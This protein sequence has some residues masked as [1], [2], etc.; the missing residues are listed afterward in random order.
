MQMKMDSERE[1]EG[2]VGEVVEEQN[3][4]RSW[5]LLNLLLSLETIEEHKEKNV[6]DLLGV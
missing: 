4:K 2:E 1:G 5:V 3:T 6:M